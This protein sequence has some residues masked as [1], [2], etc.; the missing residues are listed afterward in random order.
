MTAKPPQRES[1]WLRRAV[2]LLAH[3]LGALVLSILVSFERGTTM[4]APFFFLPL[5]CFSAVLAGPMVIGAY[6]RDPGKSTTRLIAGTAGRAAAS[7]LLI[8]ILSLVL[9]NFFLGRGQPIL[10]TVE[11]SIWAVVLSITAGVSTAALLGLA[12][13]AAVTAAKW[14]F[15]CHDSCCHFDLSDA[16]IP[17]DI[18]LVRPS[19]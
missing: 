17:L 3:F 9:M 16:P 12:S 7:M 5:S 14:G 13:R 8:V 2:Q 15:S 4:C 1:G 6:Q 18:L 11:T 19:G 10:P